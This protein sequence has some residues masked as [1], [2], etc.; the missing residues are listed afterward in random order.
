MI[1]TKLILKS[2]VVLILFFTLFFNFRNTTNTSVKI[3]K[4]PKVL[5]TSKSIVVTKNVKIK[6]YFSYLDSVVESVNEIEN[7]N[8]T[9]HLFVRFNPWLIDSL[10]ATDYY[11]MIEKDS[12]VY[13]QKEMIV[14]KKGHQLLVPDST[15]VD[16]LL[17]IFNT[18]FLDIN[19][20]EYKLRVCMDS[21][22]LYD[23]P[24][25]VGRNEKKY[26]KMGDRLTDLKTKT[27]IGTIVNHV[28]DPDYYNPATGRQY[29]LTRRD[30]KNVTKLPQIPWIVTEINGVRNGQLIHPTTNPNTLSKAYSNGC[31]GTKEG[32]AWVIYYYAPIN[33][34]VI[35]RYDL[36]TVNK[37]GDTINFKNI[38]G[39]NIKQ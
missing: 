35:I 21:V 14:L 24:V 16:S 33:T 34:K 6:N 15:A 4:K 31:I 12:F 27:G 8:L 23:F 25:R 19:I 20:P 9:E 32:D 10:A 18:T 13:N 11:K 3:A 5:K 30:D 1:P 37:Q 39:Y 2:V 17:T 7:Y 26:L 38:Y 29:F 22:I 28:K 36:S